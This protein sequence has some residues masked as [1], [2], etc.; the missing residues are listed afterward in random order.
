[1]ER[2]NQINDL[3]N[4]MIP[5]DLDPRIRQDVVQEVAI[6]LLEGK[7]LT[8]VGL[9]RIIR[10]QYGDKMRSLDKPD[11]LGRSLLEYHQVTL[12]IPNINEKRRPKVHPAEWYKQK[13]SLTGTW[14]RPRTW[15]YVDNLVVW[16]QYHGREACGM[17][18]GWAEK[19]FLSLHAVCPNCSHLMHLHNRR[20]GRDGISV[21][22]WLCR[23]CDA[24]VCYEGPKTWAD[25]AKSPIRNSKRVHSRATFV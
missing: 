20:N 8:S 6:V 10:R 9:K 4:N 19:N 3:A 2:P 24:H 15:F 11:L 7:S 21:W 25:R 23:I 14:G 5:T 1:M 12:P 22:G 16:R 13:G 17:G 18:G